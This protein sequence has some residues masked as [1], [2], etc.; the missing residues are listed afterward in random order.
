MKWPPSEESNR[1]Q[2]SDSQRM[3]NG[4]EMPKL[5]SGESDQLLTHLAAA[6]QEGL[7]LAEGL[8]AAAEEATS[9]RLARALR[10]TAD[11]IE[12]GRPLAELL[13]TTKDRLPRH[14]AG[15]VAAAARTERF[16]EALSELIEHH[17]CVRQLRKSVVASLAYPLLVLAFGVLLLVLAQIYVFSHFEALFKEFELELTPMTVAFLWWTRVGTWLILGMLAAVALGSALLRLVAG[18]A[19]WRRVYA[20]LP[21]FGPLS[22]W[23]GVSDWSR[24]L[25]MLIDQCV[26]LP[27][28][29][30]LAAD[31]VHD[32]NVAEVC[33][34]MS[35]HARQGQ[36]LS[37]LLA[38]THRLPTLLVPLATWGEETDSLAEA[39][40]TASDLFEKRIRL[41]AIFLRTALPPIVFVFIGFFGALMVTTLTMPMVKLIEYL[42]Y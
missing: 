4:R 41:R 14:I 6:G 15:L 42:S 1:I 30:S 12:Q 24:L 18:A 38:E 17:R 8:R 13:Q 25:G 36:P 28:A 19:I 37:H 27:E 31:G 11:A 7:P 21:I 33:Q 34:V 35:T 32:A 3:T 26:P 40:Y 29:L 2:A 9:Q 23:S 20:T 39:M 16:G 10:S 22:H 5:S